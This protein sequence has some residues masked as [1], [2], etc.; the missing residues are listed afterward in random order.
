MSDAN[1]NDAEQ[2]VQVLEKRVRKLKEDNTILESKKEVLEE[3]INAQAEKPGVEEAKYG[4]L[5]DKYA[6]LQEAH[7]ALQ[8]EHEALKERNEALQE[9]LEAV[10]DKATRFESLKAEHAKLQDQYTALE[11]ERDALHQKLEDYETPPTLQKVEAA[12]IRAEEAEAASQSLREALNRK[13]VTIERLQ[14]KLDARETDS[15]PPERSSDAVSPSGTASVVSEV[16]V[17]WCRSKRALI[18]RYYMFERKLHESHPNTR[19]T[20]IYAD[21]NGT[22]QA[23]GGDTADAFWLVETGAGPLALPIPQRTGTFEALSPAYAGAGIAP[24]ALGEITPA[25]LVPDIKGYQL[26]SR[27]QLHG[28]PQTSEPDDKANEPVATVPAS[29]EPEANQKDE[30]AS[31]VGEILSSTPS[32]SE[33]S[34]DMADVPAD[35]TQ[36]EQ[37]SSSEI[38]ES[39]ETNNDAEAVNSVLPAEEKTQSATAIEGDSNDSGSDSESRPSEQKDDGAASP[40]WAENPST[41]DAAKKELENNL[42][43]HIDD[44]LSTRTRKGFPIS[45]TLAEAVNREQAINE[46]TNAVEQ[47]DNTMGKWIMHCPLKENIARIAPGRYLIVQKGAVEEM[48]DWA[49]NLHNFLHRVRDSVLSDGMHVAMVIAEPDDEASELCKRLARKFDTAREKGQFEV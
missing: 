38:V 17:D 41:V 16:F 32:T 2:R 8:K 43:P 24:E 33:L 25:R 27:G 10:E 35:Q 19:V 23:G 20:P 15:V 12:Q 31:G 3:K 13:E 30:K 45:F 7:T 9:R 37:A 46:G 22:F 47:V 40:A 1:K 6:Q 14:E 5:R 4:T 26:E 42:M 11:E 18:D 21:A 36:E 44:V 49:R 34:A 39:K 28:S 48:K 29:P